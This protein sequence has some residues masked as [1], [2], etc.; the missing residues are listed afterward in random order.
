MKK[1]S[2]CGALFSFQMV[3]A[4]ALL[5]GIQRAARAAGRIPPRSPRPRRDRRP[6]RVPW[7]GG[8]CGVSRRRARARHAGVRDRAGVRVDATTDF[9]GDLTSSLRMTGVPTSGWVPGAW[10]APADRRPSR[11][12][13]SSMAA[14]ASS[15]RSSSGES[16]RRR[17]LQGFLELLGHIRENRRIGRGRARPQASSLAR[18]GSAGKLGGAGGG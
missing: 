4:S 3:A 14:E 15:V 2:A 18:T 17:A 1:G 13:L 9:L 7:R 6:F 8:G 10:A 16:G 5:A 12:G 11:S